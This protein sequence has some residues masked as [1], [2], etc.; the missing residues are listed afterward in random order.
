MAQV[1][2]A[3][4]EQPAEEQP[5]DRMPGF[6]HSNAWIFGTM[7][8]SALCS[9][10]AAFVLSYDAIELAADPTAALSCNINSVLN[11]GAVGV[12]NQAAIFGF[13]NAFLG[14][15]TEPVVITIAVAG[16][17]GV[18]FKRWFMFT[19]QVIYLLGLIFAYWL[20][21]QSMFNI[22]A[23]CPWC[24]VITVG[25]TLVFMTL[26]HYNIRENNLY[27]PPAA[28]ARAESFVRSDADVFVIAGWLL[29]LAAAIV[30][31]YGAALFG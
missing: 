28:Q 16:L 21:Y 17:T 6:R 27:L 23:L 22:G 18:R 26:L 24:L 20:F 11:C 5:R 15:M 4:T 14:L 12:S 29:F 31:K 3:A 9:L 19:A 10:T 7:L 8:F 30:L 13:P 1:D 2:T 25:T